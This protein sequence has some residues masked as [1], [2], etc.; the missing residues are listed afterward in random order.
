MH[1]FQ[2]TQCAS[3]P[4]PKDE[5]EA[6]SSGIS[7]PCPLLT[8]PDVLCFYPPCKSAPKERNDNNDD[9]DNGKG[10]CRTRLQPALLVIT[11]VALNY[12]IT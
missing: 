11:L 6:C 4:R 12:A 10:G 7:V 8:S 1:I 2:E 5:T 9:L 3:Q